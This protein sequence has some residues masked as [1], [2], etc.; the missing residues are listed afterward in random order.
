VRFIRPPEPPAELE[1]LGVLRPGR[2]D[3]AFHQ[4]EQAQISDP[5]T[6]GSLWAAVD[7][8]ATDEA[9]WVPLIT[10]GWVDIV[11]RRLGNY[12]ANTVWGM[13]LD[14]VWVR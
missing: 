13:L 2:V 5:T 6:A 3:R 7:R 12:E 11:S 14:Q 9:P 4:A 10:A 1:C 8:L